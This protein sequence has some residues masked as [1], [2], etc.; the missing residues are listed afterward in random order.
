MEM[1]N[2]EIVRSY[3][4]AKF[5]EEQIKI[6]ADLNVCS[7][8]RI[9]R[10]LKEGGVDPEEL[11]K[12]TER[13]AREPREARKQKPKMTPPKAPS[14]IVL[15][16]EIEDKLRKQV[17]RYGGRCLK[18]VS[19][20]ESGVPDRIVLLPK[21]RIVFVETKRPKGGVLSSLQKYWGR[22]L[23]DLGFEA[24][25]IWSQEDLADFEREVLKR[26]ADV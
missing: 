11:P 14:P 8:A 5:P 21:G 26:E 23:Q 22:T 20:G 3:R 25:V 2:E 10:I 18:W 4:Q 15:E 12:L 7:R 24:R 19:P 16:R 9:V 17:K 6:L 13:D 1:T